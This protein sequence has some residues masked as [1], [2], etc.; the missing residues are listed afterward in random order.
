MEGGELASRHMTG[1][2]SPHWS[3]GRWFPELP[4]IDP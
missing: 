4:S 3:D 2:L 1:M